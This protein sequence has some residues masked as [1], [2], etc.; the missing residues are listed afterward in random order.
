[1]PNPDCYLTKKEEAAVVGAIQAAEKQTS[2][3]IRVHIE[4]RSKKDPMERAKEVFFQLEMNKTKAQNGVLF[5]L[6]M[7][8]R[9]FAVLGDAGIDKVV[10]SDFWESVKEMV[11]SEFKKGN[12][13]KGLQ[14]G[15]A[16]A[17]AKLKKFFPYQSGDVNEL[18]DAIS[19]V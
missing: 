9:R 18:T 3:E 17:G 15:V 16:E 14:L 19:K 2:G 7:Q 6:A 10:P 11:L 4:S 1:M 8:Q 5:Y 12:V 13:A